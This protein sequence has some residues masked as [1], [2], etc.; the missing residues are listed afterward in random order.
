VQKL[1][2]RSISIY[3][4]GVPSLNMITQMTYSSGAQVDMKK[5]GTGKREEDPC[6]VPAILES[7]GIT[8]SRM[9]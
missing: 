8:A 4:A 1:G 9:N 2:S 6:D 3:K 5:D 7:Q